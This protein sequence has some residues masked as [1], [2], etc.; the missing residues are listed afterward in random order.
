MELQLT[1]D[2][3]MELN[4]TNKEV[5]QFVLT[6]SKV[7]NL[8]KFVKEIGIKGYSKMKKAELIDLIN[9]KLNLKNSSQEEVVDQNVSNLEIN[10]NVK[11]LDIPEELKP[12]SHKYTEKFSE[13][14]YFHK[15]W[16]KKLLKRRFYILSKMLHPDTS[17]YKDDKEF[18]LMVE[19]YNIRK[20]LIGINEYDLDSIYDV[21]TMFKINQYFAS[22]SGF[23]IEYVEYQIKTFG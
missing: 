3:L 20:K 12:T 1:F 22:H 10:S 17:T 4:E 16:N 6:K 9:T 21:D 18:L 11:L 7:S 19:E 8:K 2:V 5:T 14:T 23:S 13:V 15:I